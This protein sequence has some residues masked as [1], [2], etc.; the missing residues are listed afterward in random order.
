[1]V[2]DDESPARVEPHTTLS[3]ASVLAEPARLRPAD[4]AVVEGEQQVTYGELWEQVRAHAAALLARGVE[5]GDRVAIV[6]PNV[7]DFVRAYYAVLTAGAVVV[8]V[9]LLLVPDEAAYL[10]RNS[11]AKLVIGHT[12][13]LALAAESARRAG[14]PLVSVGPAV[15]GPE[16]PDS[17]TEVA[18]AAEPVRSFTTRGP[19]DPAVIFYTSGTTGRPKGAVLTLSLIHI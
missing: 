6:A 9:P 12:S 19:D 14:I 1:M 3:L 13:Q 8:P 15:P 11:G 4:T 10:L 16:A 5:P 17:L 7:I 18:A 2:N